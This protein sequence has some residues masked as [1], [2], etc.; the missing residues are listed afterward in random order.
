MEI[1]YCKKCHEKKCGENFGKTVARLEA[2]KGVESVQN[3]CISYCGPGRKQYF[4]TIDDELVVAQTLEE[5][6][7][8]IEEYNDN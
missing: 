5:L 2:I 8:N 7:K 3:Y 6:I 4:C 1:L